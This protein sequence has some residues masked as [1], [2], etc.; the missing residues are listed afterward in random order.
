MLPCA[1]VT[2]SRE[3]RRF[4]SNTSTVFQAKRTGALATTLLPP[5]QFRSF[6]RTL[7]TTSREQSLL[8]DYIALEDKL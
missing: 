3:R 8:L 2:D 4:S 6:A 7:K 5:N 1:A